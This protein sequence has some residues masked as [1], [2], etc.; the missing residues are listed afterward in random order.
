[1]MSDSLTR[2]Q[3]ER[4]IPLSTLERETI[5]VDGGW[6]AVYS[7][8]RLMIDHDAVQ[9]AEIEQVGTT[10]ATWDTKCRDLENTLV[11]RHAFVT[12]QRVRMDDLEQQ[13]RGMTQERNGIAKRWKEDFELRCSLEQQLAQVTQERDHWQAKFR[14]VH[15]QQV[16]E[17]VTQRDAAEA[18]IKDLE[19]Q[20]R[21]SDMCF[22]GR[23]A[24]EA[25]GNVF[26]DHEPSCSVYLQARLTKLEEWIKF[27]KRD[28]NDEGKWESAGERC[29][30]F[31]RNCDMALEGKPA[32][33]QALAKETN[34]EQPFPTL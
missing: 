27:L 9:R 25:S 19:K 17:L 5:E 20:V 13:L 11:Q 14:H 3:V 1:M 22:C 29:V 4:F 10:L 6:C 34:G 26:E 16:C 31:Y 28:D 24:D 7:A 23:S 18:R 33:W 15:G 21:P 8:L 32:P 2:E 12:E 30:D